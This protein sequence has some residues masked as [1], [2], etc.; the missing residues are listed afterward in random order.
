MANRRHSPKRVKRLRHYDTLET[1]QA[2]GASRQTARRWRKEG[3]RTVEGH[4]PPISRG[5][6]IIA[7]LKQREAKRKR[8]C[9]P[10]RLYC[11]RCKTPKRPADGRLEYRPDTPTLGT[12]YG[13]CPDCGGRLRRRASLRTI[14]TAAGGSSVSIPQATASLI[15][16]T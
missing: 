13:E 16:T 8:P 11:F 15:E 12:L 7:F 1:A 14:K 9:G 2:T 3:L 4:R 6:D 5:E 10:G